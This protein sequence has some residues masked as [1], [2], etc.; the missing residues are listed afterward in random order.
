MTAL[1]NV[2][3]L[4]L[5]GDVI[6]IKVMLQHPMETGFRPLAM[7]GTAPRDIVKLLRCTYLGAQVI[8]IELHPAVTAN[9]FFVFHLRVGDVTGDLVFDWEDEKGNTWSQAATLNVG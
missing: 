7:G 3:P 1:I 6:E 2:P 5:S 9:P 4:A 8:E